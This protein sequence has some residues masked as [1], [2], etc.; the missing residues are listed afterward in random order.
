MA[1][2]TPIAR[3]EWRFP[4]CLAILF[5]VVGS[6]PYCYGYATAAP[7]EDF[8]GFIGRGTPGANS[9]FAFARQVAEGHHAVTNL[10]TPQSPERVYI[11]PEWWIMG[12]T[13]RLT[14]LSLVSVFHIG[15]LLTVIAFLLALYYLC[16]VTLSTPAQRRAALLL[17]SCGT[18]LGWLLVGTNGL[19]G[20]QLPLSLDAKGVSIFGYLM[21]KPHFIRAGAFAA[22]Q[23]AWFIRGDQTGQARFFAFSGLAA[24][25][26]SLIRPYQIPEAFLFLALYAAVRFARQPHTLRSVLQHTTLAGLCHAPLVLWHAIVYLKNPLGL[27]GFNSW[28][29]LFLLPQIFWLGLPF[30]ALLASLVLGWPGH[31]GQKSRPSVLALWLL[32]AFLLLHS[33]PFFRW[34]IESYFAW[35]FVPPLLFVGHIWPAVARWCASRPQPH[36]RRLTLAITI[37]AVAPGNALIYTQFFTGLHA[38]Q[39][40]WQYYLDQDTRKAIAWIEEIVTDGDLV[41]AS[42]DTS[43]FVPRLANLRVLTGQDVLT[44]NYAQQNSWVSQF[45]GTPGDEGFKQWLCQSQQVAWVLVGPAERRLGNANGTLPHG[46]ERVHTVGAVDIYAVRLVQ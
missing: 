23:Y 5:I 29:P 6:F 7:G 45:F 13:A 15:R 39:A 43:Q 12:Q 36:L 2:M 35:V 17:V 4:L 30:A 25:G 1:P 18:G 28:T 31:A 8:M 44:A 27:G 19:F 46:F 10:Y 20:T 32:A 11:N 34:G 22:L 21:N 3:R 40:P 14:G 24:A 33:H 42:H 26:H 16:A 9:Y 41:L 38:P 37:L